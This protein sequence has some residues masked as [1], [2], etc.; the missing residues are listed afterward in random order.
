M[1]L[2]PRGEA[3]GAS[4]VTSRPGH[5]DVVASKVDP[6]APSSPAPDSRAAGVSATTKVASRRREARNTSGAVRGCACGELRAT[7][8][9][10]L[11]A[12]AKPKPA[13]S[14]QPQLIPAGDDV[15]SHPG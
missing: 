10:Q 12:F 15:S 1:H 13:L 14:Q 9:P 2:G 8:R 4:R 5:D 3:R 7:S 6:P 11:A